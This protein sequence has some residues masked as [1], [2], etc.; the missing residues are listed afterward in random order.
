MFDL[1]P[2]DRAWHGLDPF[3]P[4]READDAER[5][6]FARSLPTLRT[7]VRE[8]AD[9]YSIESEL[10]GFRPEEIR[11]TVKDNRLFILAERCEDTDKK[12]DGGTYLCRE[13]IRGSLC[14]SFDLTGICTDKI[15]AAFDGGILRLTLPK[16]DRSPELT[17]R[18]P[19]RTEE[20]DT[21]ASCESVES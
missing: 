12:E 6:L 3:F 16:S 10:P 11:V 18:I 1:T 19:I 9:A 15:T 8:T 13:R 7:D 4:F 5:R 17:R 14:R 21:K 2:F 20:T